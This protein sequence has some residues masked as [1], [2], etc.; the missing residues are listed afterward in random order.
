VSTSIKKA[1]KSHK[2]RVITTPVASAY[3]PSTRSKKIIRPK[4]EPPS[5]AMSGYSV[6]GCP[7]VLLLSSAHALSQH[8]SS[9]QSSYTYTATSYQTGVPQYTQSQINTYYA[10]YQCCPPQPYQ[11]IPDYY[12]QPVPVAHTQSYQP[13]A[14]NSGYD[15]SH[16]QTQS[17]AL[18]PPTSHGPTR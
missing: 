16:W 18:D 11:I 12:V 7:C 3:R 4:Q 5:P 15:T 17:D 1:L 6:S 8:C 9:D 13:T 10:Q 14:I 2:L